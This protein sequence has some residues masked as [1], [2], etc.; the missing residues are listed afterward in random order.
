MVS[1][2]IGTPPEARGATGVE[3]EPGQAAHAAWMAWRVEGGYPDHL[4]WWRSSAPRHDAL[5]G[6]CRRRASDHHDDMVP[7]AELPEE[8]KAKYR[9]MGEAGAAVERGRWLTLWEIGFV[10]DY[11]K[12]TGNWVLRETELRKLAEV[13]AKLEALVK[14]ADDE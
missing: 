11:L 10:L 7:W 14:E 8:K 9:A 3:D 5:C 13:R 4:F 6:T 2:D 12:P 1:D